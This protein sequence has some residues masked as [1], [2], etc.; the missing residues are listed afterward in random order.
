MPLL[1]LP[2]VYLSFSPEMVVPRTLNT[3]LIVIWDKNCLAL[4]IFNMKNAF[5]LMFE[6]KHFFY[7]VLL[8]LY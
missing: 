2:L 1:H 4:H 7:K 5:V 3:E 6:K 8:V